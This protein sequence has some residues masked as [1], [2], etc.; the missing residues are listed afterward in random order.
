M[1]LSSRKHVRVSH[2]F[3][4]FHTWILPPQLPFRHQLSL[5]LSSTRSQS[6]LI[7]LLRP[8]TVTPKSGSRDHIATATSC[9]S[10]F[11]ATSSSIWTLMGTAPPP[12]RQHHHV[13]HLLQLSHHTAFRHH[14]SPL[15]L[16]YFHHSHRYQNFPS[17]I[18]RPAN[19]PP[20]SCG[21]RAM[22][23]LQRLP[24]C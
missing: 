2:P 9:L 13:Q 8:H 3:G 12:L 7:H 6:R 22:R 21:L 14:H 20:L 4:F 11:R 18:N 24:T 15:H 23:L 1:F 19:S 17:L 5:P 10:T 16:P